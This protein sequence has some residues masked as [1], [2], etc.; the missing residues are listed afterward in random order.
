[1]KNEK[2]ISVLFED[3]EDF[4]TI[5]IDYTKNKKKSYKFTNFREYSH[6]TEM[7]LSK[8][9]IGNYIEENERNFQIKQSIIKSVELYLSLTE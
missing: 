6:I 4:Q 7:L 5:T 1:M 8:E 9:Q 3:T 2:E